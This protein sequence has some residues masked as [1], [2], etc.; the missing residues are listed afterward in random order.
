MDHKKVTIKDVAKEAR[1][2]IGTVS[3]VLNA[4]VVNPK[5]RERVQKAIDKLGYQPNFFARQ[6]AGG[7]SRRILALIPE[8]KTE[9]HW[10]ILETFDACLDRKDYQ[11][12]IYPLTSMKRFEN[13]VSNMSF[14]Q[15]VEGIALLTINAD[16]LD[17]FWDSQL[18]VVLIEQ[19][20]PDLPCVFL[21]NYRGG[22]LAAQHLI[23]KDATDF[24]ALYSVVENP[25][26][27][28][29]HMEERLGGFRDVLEQENRS[30]SKDQ[31]VYGDFALGPSH[32]KLTEIL[33]KYERPGIF[34]LTDNFAL[35]LLQ[36]ASSLGKVPA[37]DFLLV[38]YDNQSWAEKVGLTTIEQPIDDFGDIGAQLILERIL[39]PEKPIRQI[40]F[41]PQLILRATT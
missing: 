40:E 34:A 41:N 18:P 4:G 24:F 3:R 9:F 7:K 15:E 13:L 14:A 12:I 31:I 6:L 21:N 28:P 17:D 1:V 10:R 37:K 36:V 11:S 27:D 35:F 5:T 23:S 19:K 22:K 26:V 16:I 33:T 8:V 39:T 25:L 29:L 30:L 32:A 2:G 20:H 38:G